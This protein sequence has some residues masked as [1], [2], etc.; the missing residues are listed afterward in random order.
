[1]SNMSYCRFENTNRDLGDCAD[2][3]E[4]MISGDDD[5]EMPEPLSSYE[6]SAAKDLADRCQRILQMLA[7]YG[8]V[9]DEEVLAADFSN[10]V[11]SLN[12]SLKGEPTLAQL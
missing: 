7:S 1:M 9:E 3:L 5:G 4:A 10:V 6:L 11:V 2:A 8:G 12:N